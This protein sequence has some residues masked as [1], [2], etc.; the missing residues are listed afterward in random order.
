MAEANHTTF[1][2]IAE[3]SRMI[4]VVEDLLFEGA[5]PPSDLAI[6]FPRSSFLWDVASGGND[7][8]PRRTEDSGQWTMDYL[9]AVVGLFR[10]IQQVSNIQ[11]DFIDEDSLNAK[12][13][14]GFKALI[15]TE[16]DVPQEGLNAVA[17]WVKGGGS[18]MTVTGAG[19]NDR[20]HNPTPVLRQVTGLQEA[21]RL[22]QMV[23][24]AAEMI[25]VANGTGALGPI[26][27][28]G[29]N[30]EYI[31]TGLH[32]L[33]GTGLGNVI[34]QD[35]GVSTLAKFSD[36]SPA[37]LRNAVGKGGSATHFT[38]MPCVHF[39]GMSVYR[40]EPHFDNVTNFTDG[41]LPVSGSRTCPLLY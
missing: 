6:L 37:I 22:R 12:D 31:G 13:L 38:F 3:A 27:A 21:P 29:P 24:S 2:M 35:S 26:T 19:V 30:R 10:A 25:A 34:A 11:V 8:G 41:T 18:L 40:E 16:P 15:L 32:R 9:A 5:V 14:A 23:T 39:N 20:Y 28:F 17:D 33:I 4:A 36:G 1:T 7:L